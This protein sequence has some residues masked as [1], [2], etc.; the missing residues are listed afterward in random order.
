MNLDFFL[1][2]EIWKAVEGMQV[3]NVRPLSKIKDEPQLDV[4]SKT[5][6]V[7]LQF[8]N[9]IFLP[10]ECN[11]H[12]S[13]TPR[14]AISPYLLVIPPA[15]NQWRCRPWKLITCSQY[16]TQLELFIRTI[17]ATNLKFFFLRISG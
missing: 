6:R 16:P 17:V 12:W 7:M 3:Q 11:I 15:M 9:H 2:L 13:R 1:D 14:Y 4:Y 8:N 5:G 10:G